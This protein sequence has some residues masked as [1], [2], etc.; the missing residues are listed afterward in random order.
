MDLELAGGMSSC[1]IDEKRPPG[2]E[3]RVSLTIES[4]ITL[5]MYC[6]FLMR[7]MFSCEISFLRANYLLSSSLI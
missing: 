1:F 5:G 6:L 7:S 2:C 4:E 3:K